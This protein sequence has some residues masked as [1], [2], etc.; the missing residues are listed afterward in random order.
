MITER[1][2]APGA[3]DIGSLDKPVASQSSLPFVHDPRFRVPVFFMIAGMALLSFERLAIVLVMPERL[4]NVTTMDLFRSFFLGL[5]FDL[6]IC[7]MLAAPLVLVSAAPTKLL[8]LRRYQ[9]FIVGYCSFFLSVMFFLC[10]V[11]FFFFEQ[12]GERLNHKSFVYLEYDYVYRL[13]LEE[14]P[15][16]WTVLATIVFLVATAWAMKRLTFV[17]P[18]R[19]QKTVE[20]PLPPFRWSNLLK[21]TVWVVLLTAL[22]VLGIRGS[23]GPKAL[24][25]G[26][27]YFTCSEPVAQLTL[28]GLFTLRES[29]YS[30]YVR[31]DEDLDEFIELPPPG[32]AVDIVVNRLRRD[33]EEFID[34]PANPLRRI[35]RTDQKQR[36]YNVVLVV[37]ESLSWHY[38]GAMDGQK[39]LT[40]NL[41]ALI[42]DGILMDRCFAVGGRTTRGFSGIVSGFPDLPGRSVTTRIESEGNFLTLGTVLHRRGYETMFIY[43]GQ[44]YYDHRQSFLGSNGY[45]R[46]VFTDQFESL[47]FCTFMGY[48]DQDLF[49]QAHREFT[50]LHAQDK[51]FFA[52]LLTLSFHKKYQVPP[53]PNPRE[54]A[55]EKHQDQK[56]C[57]RYTDWAVGQFIQKARQGNY[58][59]DTIFV[60]VA[61]HMGG[62][63][64]HPNTPA[65]FRVPFVIYAP[66]IVSPR[67]VSTIC[68][69]MD[70]SPTIMLLLGGEYEHC[71]FGTDVL[72]RS[73]D[74]GRAFIY[75]GSQLVWIDGNGDIVTIPFNSS[76]RLF[77]YAPPGGVQPR[78]VNTPETQARCN[79]LAR[80]A[81]ALIQTARMLVQRGSY[82][83]HD[84]SVKNKPM[85]SSTSRP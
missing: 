42:T 31:K 47:S 28:N 32:E 22:L 20:N 40:P 23:I 14:Y 60:F 55:P 78:E 53:F 16:I 5:R 3:R 17:G 64:E 83:L 9:Y 67:R 37:L 58:F 27:A 75:F 33:N 65:S 15:F 45:S 19:T 25:T 77:E 4:A 85:F 30:V 63:L 73:S 69:Q 46:Q 52:T 7:C 12:F 56:D 18:F 10:V 21:R 43:A 8:L 62:Y 1:N 41:D 24:N 74:D 84:R 70:V 2:A 36:N 72:T 44:P 39:N 76:P 79:E 29:I 68:S 26:P 49:D 81:T 82:N 13:I 80:Q 6:L 57:I 48:C 61:D 66:K 59:D 50:S 38:I 54:G 34:D 35:T 11:D 71:F 51:P